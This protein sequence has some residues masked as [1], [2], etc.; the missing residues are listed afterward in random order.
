MAGI[1]SSEWPIPAG[2]YQELYASGITR[3]QCRGNSKGKACFANIELLRNPTTW[4]SNHSWDTEPLLGLC[5]MKKDPIQRMSFY[6]R[7]RLHNADF[8]SSVSHLRV[9]SPVDSGGLWCLEQN[10]CGADLLPTYPEEILRDKKDRG[11][12]V[13]SPDVISESGLKPQRC[14]TAA[15]REVILFP[16]WQRE[17]LVGPSHLL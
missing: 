17:D 9:R 2:P 11:S 5:Q 15:R 16:G 1:L 14:G 4:F 6:R 8:Q 3:G 7:I 12:A 13:T 10:A